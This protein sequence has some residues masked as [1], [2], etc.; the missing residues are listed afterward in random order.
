MIKIRFFVLL[1]LI[2]LGNKQI[3]GYCNID[4]NQK[5]VSHIVNY[6]YNS[7]YRDYYLQ[8]LRMKDYKWNIFPITIY[9]KQIPQR[10][11]A[12]VINAINEW[13]LYIPLKICDSVADSDITIVWIYRMPNQYRSFVGLAE[14]T[15]NQDIHK[16][17]ISILYKKHYSQFENEEIVIHELGHA[18]GLDHSPNP[19]NIMY[20]TIKP[21]KKAVKC[22][23]FVTPED[24]NT[25]I[26]VYS[27]D[28][29]I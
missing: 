4:T 11:K 27:G 24:L 7:D 16:C 15:Y 18:L 21:Y 6:K 25:L 8:S 20:N 28:T 17:K 10:Y 23:L 9:I 22:K 29:K 1:C 14:H 13:G 3:V 5:F 19:K 26:R 12:A 2:V